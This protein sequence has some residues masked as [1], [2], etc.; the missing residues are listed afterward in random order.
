MGR[1]ALVVVA[2]GGAAAVGIASF[3]WTTASKAAR[4]AAVAV[5]S[6]PATDNSELRAL[7]RQVEALRAD[8]SARDTPHPEA[9][10]VA[11]VP[12]AAEAAEAPTLTAEEAHAIKRQELNNRVESESIDRNWSHATEQR[13]DSVLRGGVAPGTTIAA[14]KCAATLC[15]VK[16]RH[17]TESSRKELP[18]AIAAVEPFD[19]GVYYFSDSDSKETVMYVLRAGSEQ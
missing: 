2:V 9:P 17:E 13:I 10:A 4:P 5:A 1:R 18:K 6:A 11:A 14:M 8:V 12:S 19:Y 7:Q 16:V 15:R 3:G